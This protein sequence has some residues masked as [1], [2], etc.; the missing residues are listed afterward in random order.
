MD[1][2]KNNEIGFDFDLKINQIGAKRAGLSP[3]DISLDELVIFESFIKYSTYANGNNTIVKGSKIY[4]HYP[5]KKVLQ[6]IP[7]LKSKSRNPIENKLKNIVK[8]K[9]LE[10][11]PRNQKMGK[12]FYCFGENYKYYSNQE[13]AR[14]TGQMCTENRADVHGKQGNTCTENSTT[15]AR[16][17]GQHL[18]QKKGTYISTYIN[19]NINTNDNEKRSNGQN[20]YS[21]DVKNQIDNKKILRDTPENRMEVLKIY[22]PYLNSKSFKSH[23]EVIAD[24]YPEVDKNDIMKTW[25][26]RADWDHVRKVKINLIGNWVRIANLDIQKNK[27][28]KTRNN[29]NLISQS[30]ANEI[31]QGLISEGI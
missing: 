23:F 28:G 30:D 11:H 9:L 2:Y 6:R 4:F 31:L 16:K 17:T 20:I 21:Y 8:N 25:L 26:L 18:H 1:K 14:K 29:K 13:P 10:A 15:P 24:K 19:N 27:N 5:W 12:A 7:F 22:Q 3:G